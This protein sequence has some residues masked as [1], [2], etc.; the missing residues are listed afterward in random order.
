[1]LLVPPSCHLWQLQHNDII[2][3]QFTMFS[4]KFN[5]PQVKRNLISSITKGDINL[6]LPCPILLDFSILFQIFCSGLQKDKFNFSFNLPIKTKSEYFTN[7][8]IK[9]LMIIR[10]LRKLLNIFFADKINL[11][12]TINLTDN[13]VILSNDVGNIYLFNSSIETLY[14]KVF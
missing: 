1:M 10:N 12:E 8:K 4:C 14:K 3:L 11:K 13:E 9:K 6:F 5:S 2:C 7:I